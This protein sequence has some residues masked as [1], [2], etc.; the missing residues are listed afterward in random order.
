MREQTLP[1]FKSQKG[2]SPG[3]LKRTKYSRLRNDSLTSLEDLPQRML[4]PRED[5]CLD[6]DFAQLDPGTPTHH[7]PSTLRDFI[8]RVANIRLQSPI[9]LRGMRGQTD[10]E[11]RTIDG[12]TDRPLSRAEWSSGRFCSQPSLNVPL[13]TNN[14][15]LR[16]TKRPITLHRMASLPWTPGCPCSQHRDGLCRLKTSLAVDDC[17]VEE[18]ADRVVHHHIKYMGSVEVTQSMRTLDF[19]T[20]MKVTREAI[21]RLCERTSAK[22]AVK[23][24]RPVCKGLSALLGQINLQFSGS[25]SILTVSTDSVTLIAASSLQKIAHHPMQAISFA[26]GGDPDMAD[27]IAY[28][29]KDLVNQRACHILECPRGCAG[30]VINS[31]GQA[32]E[33][34]FRQLLSHTPSLLSNNPRSAAVRICH[35]W[36]PEETITDQRLE[37]EGEAR[38]HRDYYNVIPGK[39]PPAGGIEDLLI[40][41][42]DKQDADI[43]GVCSSQPVSLCENC[44]ITEETPAPPAD[45]VVSVVSAKQCTPLSDTRI[46]LI[47]EEGWFHGRLGREQAES[48]LTCSGD[49]LVRESSSASRQYVLSGMEGATVR[50]LLL[51][52]PHGQVRTRDQVFLSVGHLVRFHMENQMPIVS[53]SS[54]LCL[55]QPILQRH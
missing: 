20:R 31:I 21:S 30:E 11:D 12:H 19:D 10:S 5:L 54:E 16:C 4:P 32:F 47:Q 27:Y 46:H 9:S 44:S 7:G 26:S 14:L 3:M 13:S 34:R 24:K 35:K 45:S 37:Q 39:T 51:V 55:K 25:R 1:R 50:H 2:L 42:E 28:V 41:R 43:Q 15:A 6:S 29:A 52:D 17:T 23:T 49:F 8:P 38:K 53:G 48:L 22:R 40:T 36:S 18:T 33:T